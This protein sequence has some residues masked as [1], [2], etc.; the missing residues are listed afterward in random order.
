MLKY[1]FSQFTISLAKNQIVELIT[2]FIQ[3]IEMINDDA[4]KKQKL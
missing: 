1:N 4:N 2:I 3:K